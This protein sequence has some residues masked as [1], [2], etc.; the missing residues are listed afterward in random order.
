MYIFFINS[1]SFTLEISTLIL[2]GTAW[3]KSIGKIT[4]PSK[5]FES[6]IISFSF[7]NSMDD[8]RPGP[9]NEIISLLE[10]RVPLLAAVGGPMIAF[11]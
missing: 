5:L 4:T 11:N 9:V 7:L 2:F 1:V 6:I 3:K 8:N 10:K